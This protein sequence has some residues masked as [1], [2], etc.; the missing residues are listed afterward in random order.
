MSQRR[1]T[2]SDPVRGELEVTAG[3]NRPLQCSFLV[4]LG[5]NNLLYSNLE[6]PEGCDVPPKKACRVLERLGVPIPEGFIDALE[7]DRALKRGNLVA[8]YLLYTGEGVA[9]FELWRRFD[10]AEASAFLED[11]HD[12]VLVWVMSEVTANLEG[13]KYCVQQGDGVQR[14]LF[15]ERDG[16]ELRVGDVVRV[17]RPNG[18][19]SYLEWTGERLASFDLP[20]ESPSG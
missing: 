18:R 12:P 20:L 1:Y 10:D 9:Q 8:T 11:T 19:M 4:I 13:A 16:P 14:V 7:R 5:D 17:Q 15:D 2:V 3:W 6:D